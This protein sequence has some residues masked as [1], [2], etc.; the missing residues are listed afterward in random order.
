ME[1]KLPRLS[2]NQHLVKR[3]HLLVCNNN[4]DLADIVTTELHVRESPAFVKSMI[5]LKYIVVVT[6]S[7]MFGGQSV[8]RYDLGSG[9]LCF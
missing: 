5:F 1:R 7:Q 8:V 9:C 3:I 2:Y 6:V 4:Y